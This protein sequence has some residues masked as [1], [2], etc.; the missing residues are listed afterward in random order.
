[1]TRLVRSRLARA[2]MTPALAFGLV[3]AQ[4]T[5]Q[6]PPLPDSVVEA[7]TTALAASLR[8]PVCQGLSIQDSPSELAQQMR[9]LIREQVAS[10]KTDADVRDYFLS[11]YGEFILLEPRARGFNLLAYLLPVA[12]LVTGAL[13]VGWNVR[14]WT[15]PSEPAPHG[16]EP[17][18]A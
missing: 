14:R 9:S 13:V 17:P 15:R 1:M 7:R 18:A 12:V 3:A 4:P 2:A 16:G 8:C 10:G 5:R 11:K 6:A